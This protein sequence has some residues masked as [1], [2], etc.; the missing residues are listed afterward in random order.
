[1]EDLRGV[2]RGPVRGCCGD[3]R[4]DGEGLSQGSHLEK[5]QGFNVGDTKKRPRDSGRGQMPEGEEEGHQEGVLVSG[6]GN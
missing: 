6:L 4:R 5:R 1:M 2:G 3:L